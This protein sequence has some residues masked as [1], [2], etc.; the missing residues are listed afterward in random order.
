MPSM[1][2]ETKFYEFLKEYAGNI[3]ELKGVR[4]KYI[5]LLPP[6]YA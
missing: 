1:D 6:D 2:I 4:L 3:A 5:L